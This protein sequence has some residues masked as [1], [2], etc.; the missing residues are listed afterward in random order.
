M[1]R[2]PHASAS[3]ETVKNRLSRQN[4]RLQTIISVDQVFRGDR[5]AEIQGLL[6]VRKSNLPEPES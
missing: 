4:P 6:G 1:V 3:T 2:I 5:E